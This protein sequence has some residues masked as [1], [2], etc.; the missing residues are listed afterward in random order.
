MNNSYINKS[1][2]KYRDDGLY[3]HVCAFH[4]CEKVFYGSLKKK[5]CCDKCK[6]RA[7]SLK[8]SIINKALK[9][10][11]VKIKK[12]VRILLKIFKPSDE[13]FFSVHENKLIE[14]SFPFDVPTNKIKI[15][16]YDGEMNSFGIFC[17]DRR[18]P[19]F[20]FYKLD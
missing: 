11:D 5:Y 7:N 4:L 15:N 19:Y 20:V 3:E 6:Q 18:G 12:A 9:Q 17:F 14:L 2:L 13:G 16:A 1:K 10:D 8:V